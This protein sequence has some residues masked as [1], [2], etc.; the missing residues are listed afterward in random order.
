MPYLEDGNDYIFIKRINNQDYFNIKSIN[1]KTHKIN[2][3]QYVNILHADICYKRNGKEKGELVCFRDLDYR[4]NRHKDMVEI[5][6]LTGEINS[7]F[8]NNMV[9]LILPIEC[10]EKCKFKEVNERSN[11]NE[12]EVFLY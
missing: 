12:F 1:S 10:Y 3:I 8:N 4:V 11:Y 6:H 9:R 7:P 2:L 5:F